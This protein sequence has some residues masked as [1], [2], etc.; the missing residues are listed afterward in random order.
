M[1]KKLQIE[2]NSEMQSQ[3]ASEPFSKFHNVQK[4]FAE[5]KIQ[6]QHMLSYHIDLPIFLW[7][8]KFPQLYVSWELIS[9]AQSVP[10]V[11]S[12]LLATKKILILCSFQWL[13][14][15]YMF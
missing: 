13:L 4:Y 15:S 12:G 5:I 7:Q 11:I 2:I 14:V 8:T 3:Q 9:D 10:Q 1:S 6:V